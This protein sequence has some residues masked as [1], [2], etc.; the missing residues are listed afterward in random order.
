MSAPPA[1]PMPA[2]APPAAPTRISGHLWQVDAV[3]LL[4]FAAVIS[5]HVLAYTEQPN[6]RVAAGTMMLLQFGRIVFFALS[7]FVLVYSTMGRR[8]RPG[9]FWRKRILYVAVPYLVWSFL[10]YLY[11]VYGPWHVQP[12]SAHVIWLDLVTGGA[13]YHL[14]FLLVTMQL[15]LV[16]PLIRGFVVRTA[17]WAVPILVVVSIADLLWMAALQWTSVPAHGTE[18]WLFNHAYELLPTYAMWI[19]AGCY[20]AVH[21]PRLQ[22]IVDR[23]P[24]RLLAVAGVAV[25]GALANYAYQLDKKPPRDANQVLQPG[26]SLACLAAVIVLYVVGSRWAAG[27]RR[28]QA[29][30]ALLSEASFGVYLA[31]PMVLQFLLDYCGFGNTDQTMPPVIA[32]V[33]AYVMTLVG[34]TAISLVAQRTPLSLPLTGRA[35]REKAKKVPAR[36]DRPPG[37]EPMGDE[38]RSEALALC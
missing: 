13:D 24:R 17:R 15:Y 4:T 3:R 31:H 26:S 19:L 1:A 23:Y 12:L 37:D 18:R 10:Y 25:A 28:H 20:A 8:I 9:S 38:P 14:Y 16:F 2:A 34:A 22:Q 6:N 36:A 35:W 5:V 27:R 32:T 33:V 11:D 21:L 30:I 7:G 29:T